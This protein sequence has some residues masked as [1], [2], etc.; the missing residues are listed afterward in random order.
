[1]GSSKT[2]HDDPRKLVSIRTKKIVLALQ[3]LQVMEFTPMCC[4]D[5]S[6]YQHDMEDLKTRLQKA[7]E[8]NAIFCLGND[9]AV[10]LFTRK[11]MQVLHSYLPLKC[12][13]LQAVK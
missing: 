11:Y 1:M 12:K 6:L 10:T 5:L 8:I 13:Y 7:L 9:K 4:V 2:I 3:L